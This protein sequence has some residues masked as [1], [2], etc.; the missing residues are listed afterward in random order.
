MDEP[1]VE[2]SNPAISFRLNL[3]KGNP[4]IVCEQRTSE[5]ESADTTS[6]QAYVLKANSTAVRIPF[7]LKNARLTYTWS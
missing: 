3:V 4:E 7:Q 1:V 2:P 5:N 6:R